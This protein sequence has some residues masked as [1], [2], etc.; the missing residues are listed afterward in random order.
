MDPSP[1]NEQA[2]RLF[3]ASLVFSLFSCGLTVGGYT[4]KWLARALFGSAGTFA[5]L[6]IFWPEIAPSLTTNTVFTASQIASNSWVWFGTFAFTVVA[7]VAGSMLKE[8]QN[9]LRQNPQRPTSIINPPQT[10]AKTFP[11]KRTALPLRAVTKGEDGSIVPARNQAKFSSVAWLISFTNI[12]DRAHTISA[13]LL[14]SHSGRGGREMLRTIQSPVWLMNIGATVS[15]ESHEVRDLVLAVQNIDK[16]VE[17]YSVEDHR[18]TAYSHLGIEAY[19]LD[20]IKTSIEVEL[21]LDSGPE[22]E[23]FHCGVDF[24][25]FRGI[26]LP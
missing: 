2:I 9:P 15:L 6:A 14:Y 17:W 11:I 24:K 12:D 20:P 7:L 23:S 25:T 4:N 22:K 26:D 5:L 19:S 10:V 13:R 18:L 3:L 8:L 16:P 1:I 21:L